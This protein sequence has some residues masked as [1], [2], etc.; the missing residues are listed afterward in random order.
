MSILE[1]NKNKVIPFPT[2]QNNRTKKAVN[3]EVVFP[4][5]SK[6]LTLDLENQPEAIINLFTE[7]INNILSN[8]EMGLYPKSAELNVVECLTNKPTHQTNKGDEN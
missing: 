7:G 8:I 3:F 4:S 5:E 1:D 6:I 2:G